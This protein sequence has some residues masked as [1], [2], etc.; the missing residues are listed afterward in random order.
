MLKLIYVILKKVVEL[1]KIPF[2]L[3]AIEKLNTNSLSVIVKVSQSATHIA[4]RKNF[5]FLSTGKAYVSGT[6]SIDLA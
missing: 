2:A 1:S 6:K 4:T 5:G 3:S